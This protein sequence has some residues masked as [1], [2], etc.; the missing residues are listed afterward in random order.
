MIN[1]IIKLMKEILYLL[2]II[3]NILKALLYIYIILYYIYYFF[4]NSFKRLFSISS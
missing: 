3:K 4:T 2:E 1:K